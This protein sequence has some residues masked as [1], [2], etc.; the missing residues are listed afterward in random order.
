MK[1]FGNVPVRTFAAPSDL[2]RMWRMTRDAINGGTS[3]II[4][5][6]GKRTRDWPRRRISG[7]G[8]RV[9]QQLGIPIVPVSIVGAFQHHRTGHWMFWPA[10]VTVYL[11]ATIDTSGMNKEEVPELRK[12]VREMVMQPVEESL[13][14]NAAGNTAEEKLEVEN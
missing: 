3:L 6:E 8:F 4:F 13:L 14:V 11:H 2:K 5:P 7:G 10:T 1:R 12:R 9:A